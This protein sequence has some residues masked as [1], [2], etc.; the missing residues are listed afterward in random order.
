MTTT[1]VVVAH[2]TGARFME[3]RSG[4]GRN[5]TFVSALEN[6]NGR[7]RNHEIDTDRDT[8]QHEQTSHEHVVEGFIREIAGELQ[9]ARSQGRFDD[10]ILVA[11]PRFLGGLRQAL[12]AP[13]AL[14]VVGSVSKD[15]AAI[16]SGQVAQHIADSLPL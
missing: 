1:W 7:L 8:M 10:L 6:P 13:T 11:G 2:Q 5:L 4:W 16:P 9:Q 15:L 14:K 12:D 3:H